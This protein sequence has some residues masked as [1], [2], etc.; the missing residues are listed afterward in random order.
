[1]AMNPRKG[2][3]LTE[4][5]VA[6]AIAGILV[7]LLIPAVQKVRSAAIGVQDKNAMRQ[8]VLATH[9]YETA[10]GRL[11]SATR[12]D[13]FEGPRAFVLAAIL[14]YLE[15]PGPHHYWREPFGLFY[16]IVPIYFSSADPSLSQQPFL[17]NQ[18]GPSSMAVNAI[19]FEGWATM[20]ASFADGTSSTIA[21]G[22]HYFATRTRRNEICYPGLA[23]PTFPGYDYQGARSASFA[24]KR[25][26]DVVPLTDGSPPQSR[27]SIPGVTFQVVPKFEESDGRLLQAMQPSG[28]K[29]AMMDG[30]VRTIAPGVSERVYW[31]AVTPAGGEVAPLD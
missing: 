3:T 24:D 12:F 23:A 25:L 7:A 9:H 4:V 26:R 28:L 5:L 17:F 18:F 15:V 10:E 16:Q 2:A 31:A 29:V 11:P 6:I 8:V 22:E 19:A 20:P 21:I 1:M 27:P 14:P 30:S 13:R